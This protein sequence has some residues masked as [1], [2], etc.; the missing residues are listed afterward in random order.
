MCIL[1]VLSHRDVHPALLNKMSSARK[2]K[3]AGRWA[4]KLQKTDSKSS[5]HMVH[6]YSNYSL[7]IFKEQLI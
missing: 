2:K 4:G 5:G 3:K 7:L 1:N 6:F